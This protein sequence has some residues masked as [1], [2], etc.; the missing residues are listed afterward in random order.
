MNKRI[1][2][3]LLVFF[4]VAISGYAF[5]YLALGLEVGFPSMKPEE[6]RNSLLW[7]SFFYLHIIFG[8][9]AL[10][11]GVFQFSGRLRQKVTLHRTLGATYLAGVVLGGGA[12]FALSLFAEGGIVAKTGFN[13]LAITWLFTSWKAYDSIKKRD[14]DSHQAWMIRSYAACC[15][16]ITLRLVLPFETAVLRMDFTTS[17]QI[18]AWLC[19]VP[20]MLWAEWFLQRKE[21]LSHA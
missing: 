6:V 16:A 9:L 18:V 15:A 12:G 17:Y 4:A 20:N 10:L 3:G 11:V 21:R 5:S 8:G 13:L 19:W 1:I 2:Y 7:Q 14:I